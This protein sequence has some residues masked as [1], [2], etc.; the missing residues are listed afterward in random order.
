[1]ISVK[2]LL[3][4]DWT[5]SKGTCFESLRSTRLCHKSSRQP[6][7]TEL[8][9]LAPTLHGGPDLIRTKAKTLCHLTQCDSRPLCSAPWQASEQP[10]RGRD[11]LRVKIVS[12]WALAGAWL[13]SQST[14]S[15][16]LEK[17]RIKSTSYWYAPSPLPVPVNRV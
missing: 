6:G 15:G 7:L 2:A 12:S 11:P 17:P 14:T 8:P 3:H 9:T 4:L 5:H 1:V 16:S 10:R 13:Y